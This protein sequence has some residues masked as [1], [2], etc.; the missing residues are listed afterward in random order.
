M[1]APVG[2]FDLENSEPHERFPPDGQPEQRGAW[3]RPFLLLLVLAMASAYLAWGEP[4]AAGHR[5]A[6]DGMLKLRD[7]SAWRDLLGRSAYLQYGSALTKNQTQV[8]TTTAEQQ[9]S[10]PA[11]GALASA[12]VEEAQPSTETQVPEAVQPSTT[13]IMHAYS[14]D[15]V[16]KEFMDEADKLNPA[17]MEHKSL[18]SIAHMLHSMSEEVSKPPTM[19]RLPAPA[20][21]RA[22]AAQADGSLLHS[23]LAPRERLSD[24]NKC[25]RDEE[26]FP[27]VAG[28]CYKKCSDLTAGYF[29]IR[30]SP[31]S[32]CESEP[33][34]FSNTKIHL[35]FCSGFDVAGD[36][37]GLGCPNF[38]GACLTDEELFG[39]LCYKKCSLFPMAG[40]FTH[41]VAPSLC[42]STKGFRCLLPKYLKFS[43][44]FAVGGGAHDGSADTPA[45]P[46]PPLKELTEIGA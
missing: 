18:K 41:R 4:S 38:E 10:T 39:G 1:Y 15:G 34:G 14:L 35:S 23:G 3:H 32:C 42:C 16:V 21:L 28:T 13:T 8:R 29:P 17:S 12:A 5:V 27:V 22:E 20:P 40:T 45:F 26:E 19:L 6:T 43:A 11:P 46:H 7:D 37:E 24:G 9:S 2:S 33:C 44:S 36:R 31:F 25:A 30:T